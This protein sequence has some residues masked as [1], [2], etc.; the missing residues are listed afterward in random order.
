M[1]DIETNKLLMIIIAILIPPVAIFLKRGVGIELVINIVLCFLF[2][3]PGLIHAL[4]VVL[5]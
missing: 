5:R 2:Y 1:S 4:W 3:F